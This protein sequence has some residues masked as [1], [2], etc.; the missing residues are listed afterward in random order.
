M[1]LSF[2]SF[3]QNLSYH[4]LYWLRDSSSYFL[5]SFPLLRHST[6]VLIILVE[7]LEVVNEASGARQRLHAPLAIGDFGSFIAV[8]PDLIEPTELGKTNG[9][10]GRVFPFLVLYNGF[11]AKSGIGYGSC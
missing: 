8:A 3:S 4:S 10:C 2:V 9:I 7:P 5:F 11:K 1:I 6:L